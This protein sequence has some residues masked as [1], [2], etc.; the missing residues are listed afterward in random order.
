MR[1]FGFFNGLI[2]VKCRQTLVLSSRLFL[3]SASTRSSLVFL[4]FF[5]LLLQPFQI[6]EDE[7]R[8]IVELLCVLVTCT[9][10]GFHNWIFPHSIY[11]PINSSGVQKLS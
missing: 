10:N 8:I 4:S 3:T 1:L 7:T 9:P 11:P 6:L 2:G 5:E